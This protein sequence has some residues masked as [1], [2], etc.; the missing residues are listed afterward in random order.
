M[1]AAM[2]TAGMISVGH[3][4]DQEPNLRQEQDQMQKNVSNSLAHKKAIS[5][6]LFVIFAKGFKAFSRYG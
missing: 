6:N 2:V 3:P 4:V 1:T 5:F